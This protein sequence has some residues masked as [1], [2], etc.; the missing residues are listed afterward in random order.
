M[1]AVPGARNEELQRLR[2]AVLAILPGPDEEPVSTTDL[3]AALQL[4]VYE[5]STRLWP[6]LDRLAKD[7]VVE[8]C[9]R[10]GQTVRFWRLAAAEAAAES[11]PHPSREAQ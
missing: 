10:A 3:G 7:G 11:D 2:A 5:H 8:R 4:S 1:N 6:I 9:V